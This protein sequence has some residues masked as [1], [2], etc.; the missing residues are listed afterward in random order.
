MATMG[1]TVFRD[2]ISWRQMQ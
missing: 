2:V 1:I